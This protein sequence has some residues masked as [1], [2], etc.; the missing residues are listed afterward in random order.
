MDQQCSVLGIGAS[1]RRL[2]VAGK[3]FLAP[4][5]RQ[6]SAS[7]SKR[8]KTCLRA[9]PGRWIKSWDSFL[10]LRRCSGE[11]TCTK[12]CCTASVRRR[13][14]LAY[15]ASSM[16]AAAF[17]RCLA[18]ISQLGRVALATGALLC[19]VCFSYRRGQGHLLC[20]L[21]A[22]LFFTPRHRVS[23]FSLPTS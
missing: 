14:E 2:S 20:M 11:V 22:A 19:A 6:T 18:C 1:D 9:L 8:L 12:R 13:L 7:G 23:G 3:P 21:H 10:I 16:T 15:S 5:P 17:V 4:N